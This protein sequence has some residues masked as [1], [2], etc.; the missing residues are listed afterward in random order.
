MPLYLPQSFAP[1]W[2]STSP[3]IPTTGVTPFTR[4]RAGRRLPAFMP[5]SGLDSPLQPGMAFNKIGFATAPGVG[6]GLPTLLGLASATTVGTATARAVATTNFMSQTKRLGIVSAATAGSQASWRIAAAAYFTSTTAGMGGFYFVLR[7]CNDTIAS[8]GDR[9]FMGMS[10]GSGA[11]ANVDPS[12]LINSCG[13]GCDAGDTGNWQFMTNNGAGTAT[14]TD[15]GANF[16]KSSLTNVYELRMFIK[17]GATQLWWS[18]DRLDTTGALV[19]GT[20]VTKQPAV[21]ALMSANLSK[22]NNATAAACAFAF[23]S[24]Y[25]ETDN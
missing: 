21:N 19:E 6:N 9:L 12:T 1:D 15:L 14:K 25:V 17:P 10:A 23:I 16:A 8:T 13:M 7:F 18:A 22:W 20:E 4:Y 24:L 3:T 2:T 11:L 5:P